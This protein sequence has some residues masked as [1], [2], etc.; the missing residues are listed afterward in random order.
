[1]PEIL[2]ALLHRNLH[3][4]MQGRGIVAANPT[5]NKKFKSPLKAG[6]FFKLSEVNNLASFSWR[7]LEKTIWQVFIQLVIRK[8]HPDFTRGWDHL[9]ML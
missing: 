1:M 4:R 8:L 7:K 5:D 6:I 2:I 9:S 3:Q